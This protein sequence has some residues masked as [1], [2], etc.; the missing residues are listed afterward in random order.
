MVEVSIPIGHDR[1]G[2]KII[3]SN[4]KEIKPIKGQ[5]SNKDLL[6]GKGYLD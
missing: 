6:L 3:Q 2:F 5:Q 4:I 1:I